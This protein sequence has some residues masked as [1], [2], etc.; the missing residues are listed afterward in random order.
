MTQLASREQVQARQDQVQRRGRELGWMSLGLGVAQLA[1]PD[2]VRRIRGVEDSRTS[3][4]V[5]PLVGIR[6]LIHVA[7]LPPCKP[8]A[9]TGAAPPAEEDPWI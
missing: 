8:S 3:R 1:A 9:F 4:T 5:V 7:G 6:E 2:T